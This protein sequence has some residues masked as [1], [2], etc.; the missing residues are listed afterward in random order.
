MDVS[1]TI[2]D[3]LGLLSDAT[4]VR[5]L[6][7]LEGQELSVSEL[8]TVVQL[9]Q[10]TVSR[11]LRV[12]AD[13]GWV[14][15]RK[16]GTKRLYRIEPAV[17]DSASEN[18]WKLT[19]NEA[20]TAPRATQDRHRLAAVLA[21]R[22][23]RSEEFFA[24][25]AGE[26]DRLRTQLFGDRFEMAALLGLLD[27]D[28]V[29]GDLGC[30]TGSM[31]AEIAPF[32][33]RVVAVDASEA[34]LEAAEGRLARFDNVEVVRGRL[35]SLPIADD[36]LDLALM[37]LV[38][39]HASDPLAVLAETR[40]VLAPGGR[41]LLVDMA[42]HD[43]E[44]YR[45][46]MGHVWLGFEEAQLREWLAAAGFEKERLLLLPPDPSARGP[47]LLLAAAHAGGPGKG[48]NNT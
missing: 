1:R 6:T 40:R 5:L 48:R 34:M 35:E 18:L 45:H 17:L 22:R 47:A 13:G 16:D 20:R 38:L 26:W 4:R 21:E 39:H 31:S 28:Q 10:S 9:P 15:S 7:L 27:A 19:R 2:F 32:V 3:H 44:E 46:D 23:S 41:L 33:A 42:A 29:V 37:F 11:H 36:E 8:C 24:T 25:T 30:G 12:L 43:R 14:E